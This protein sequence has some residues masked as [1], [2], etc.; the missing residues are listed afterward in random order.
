MMTAC[1]SLVGGLLG[2]AV[3]VAAAH[4]ADMPKTWSPPELDKSRFVEMLSG[5]Y[6][7][8]DVGYRWNRVD[9]L[10]T[11][12]GSTSHRTDDSIGATLGAGYKYQWFRTDI[13]FDY[14]SQHDFKAYT[15][16]PAAQPQYS[17][18]IDTVSGLLN[19]YV[20]FGTWWGFTPY[21]GG[22]IGATYV[23]AQHYIDTSIMT[24]G[25]GP[26]RGQTNFSWAWMAGVAFQIKPQWLIDIGYRHLDLG[27]VH[28]IRGTDT[29]NDFMD[30]TKQSTNEIRVGL[31]YMLD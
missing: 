11:P 12:V 30:I 21:V 18:R 5:W 6:L 15:A 9:G 7:R 19:G 4:G 23:R 20:D 16:G 28:A 3:S 13:T 14:G 25:S 2:A 29:P 10:E 8:T 26:S 24:S 17:A 27:G 31:R 22:G 1:K